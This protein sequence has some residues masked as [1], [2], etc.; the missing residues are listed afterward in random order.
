MSRSGS[1]T[2]SWT[3]SGACAASASSSPPAPPSR[4][5]MT[6]AALQQRIWLETDRVYRAS[7]ERLIK[8]KTNQQVKAADRDKSNDFSSRRELRPLGAARHRQL[9]FRPLD[10]E[11]PRPLARLSAISGSAFFRRAGL[12]SVR[13]PLFR[14]HRRHEG[15]AWPR[16]RP[17]HDH[18]QRQGEGRHGRFRFRFLRSRRPEGPSFR[19]T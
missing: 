11:R 15:A 4:S 16:F 19:T 17:H 3:T 8:I 13:Q 12:G 18:R 2:R 10:A 7:A 9:R 1:A 14:Q 6:P 5:T